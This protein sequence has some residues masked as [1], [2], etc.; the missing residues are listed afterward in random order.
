MVTI[1]LAEGDEDAAPIFVGERTAPEGRYNALAWSMIPAPEGEAEGYTLVITG[2]ATREDE[3]IAFT[4][5]VEHE[6]EYVC[7]EYVGDERKG[8]LDADDVADLE[9]TFH[10]DHLFGDGDLP[11][12]D[13]L[14]EH[15][16]GFDIFAAQAEDN[17][18]EVDMAALE[19]MV[20]EDDYQMLVDI[21]PT[22]GHVGE[23]HCY[24]AMHEVG[25][26]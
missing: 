2:T 3:A 13:A 22:L 14:N 6:Y 8:I 9:M 10:F 4:I 21:L 26:E 24:E 15:A 25:Q 18:V 1:D 5:K 7:G 16:P 23:G 11:P 12:D 19:S 17:S 20:S